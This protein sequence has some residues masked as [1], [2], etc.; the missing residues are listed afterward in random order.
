VIRENDYYAQPG[1]DEWEALAASEYAAFARQALDAAAARGAA[2]Q[3]GELPYAADKA[4]TTDEVNVLGRATRVALLRD[5]PWLPEL[6][7]R[8]L[9]AIAVAPTTAKTLPSQ[10][11]LFEVA[12]SVRDCAAGRRRPARLRRAA[13]R[14][15]GRRHRGPALASRTRA[16]RRDPRPAG[17]AHRTPGPPAVQAGVP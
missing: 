8:L 11:L 5:E 9:P 12:R 6:L 7:G 1:P 14:R 2:V 17:S 3:S 4:F 16:A 10:A 13:V 15:R